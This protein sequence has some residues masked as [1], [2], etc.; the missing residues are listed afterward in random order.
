[1]RRTLVVTQM[2]LSMVLLVGALLFVGTLRNLLTLDPGFTADRLVV[3][4]LDLS[5][6][7][8]P[9]ERRVAAKKTIVDALRAL[10]DVAAA[11][12]ADIVPMSGAG[13]NNRILIGGAVQKD[14]PNFNRVSPGYF[15][16]LGTPFVAGRDLDERDD[17]SAPAVAIV[18]ESFVRKFLAGRDPL[19]ES[20]Q[21][22]E[23]PGAPRPQ[24][25]VVGV[26]KDTK[27][28]DMREPFGPIAYLAAA[29]ETDPDP[30]LSLIV[31]SAGALSATE[32]AITR[33]AAGV[34]PEISLHFDTMTSQ[35]RRTL[36]PERLMAT[37]TGFFGGLAGLIAAIGLY[38]VMSYVVAQRRN[39]IGIR[40]ALGAD[41]PAVL[42]M[43][44]RESGLLLGTGVLAGAALS[45]VAARTASALLF[46][47]SPG[48]PATFAQ[49]VAVLAGVA[50]LASYVPA[51][52]AARV[53]PCL[54]LRED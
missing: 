49:A 51:Q 50:A 43:V 54:A 52:R 37:L 25:Q 35:V 21:V 17:V 19:R 30:Y 53:D 6:A 32:S 23:A 10:P 44:L 5:R 13:W 34:H 20:F 28:R 8:L 1:L 41:R 4:G 36:L 14:Y 29:Q 9:R 48:D 33:A 39:E 16:A 22:E 18:N 3:V 40:M 12:Q 26:V 15:K 7:A 11:S 38:G 45:V 31:R 46:G 47:L 24:Y 42:K 2:A 27:Y